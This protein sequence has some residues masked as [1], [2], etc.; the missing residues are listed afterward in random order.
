MLAAG[1]ATFAAVVSHSVADGRPAPALGIVLALVVAVPVC[2]A[3]AGKRLS[4]IRLALAVVVSQFVFHGLLL[5]GVGEGG[6]ALPAITERAGHLHA[7]GVVATV[8]APLTTTHVGHDGAWM[9]VAHAIAAVVTILAL[10][11]GERALRALLS[12]SGWNLVARVLA[13]HPSPVSPPAP[14][15]WGQLPSP[16]RAVPL[17]VLR[18]RG[19]PVTA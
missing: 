8:A 18:R 4:W 15:V 6:G 1:V 17:R 7:S 5:I 12:L 11:H 10:G 16:R 2:T 19:P 3:L 13:W 14:V 9:W